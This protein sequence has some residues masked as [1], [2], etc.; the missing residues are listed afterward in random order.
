MRLQLSVRQRFRTFSRNYVFLTY[1]TIN[2]LRIPFGQLKC[3][4]KETNLEDMS[5]PLALSYSIDSVV[6]RIT[7]DKRET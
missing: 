1:S 7:S 5:H 2:V 4:N 6:A 3:D